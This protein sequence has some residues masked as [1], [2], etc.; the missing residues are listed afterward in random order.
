MEGLAETLLLLMPPLI[1]ADLGAGEGTFSQLLARRAKKVIAIDNSEKMVEYG[2]ELA[3]KHG[4]D[5]LEYR[6]GDIE[7]VPIRTGTVDLAFFSQ[8][9]H[10]A[11]HPQQA[12]GEGLIGFLGPGGRISWCWI[13]VRHNYH[14]A[15]RHVRRRVV[16]LHRGRKSPRFLRDAGF[17]GN[18]NLH[19]SSRRRIPPL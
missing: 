15:S 11:Q 5:N 12:V 9:L 2:A 14:E 10:H 3:R 1:I 16:R 13:W 17:K 18:R 6:K 7:Q 19:R 4:V 8:A